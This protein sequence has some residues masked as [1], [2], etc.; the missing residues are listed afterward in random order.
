MRA[1][2]PKVQPDHLSEGDGN[3]ASKDSTQSLGD[4]FWNRP[5][6]PPSAASLLAHPDPL[7]DLTT[8][9]RN[10]PTSET[11][12]R[13]S[14]ARLVG[15]IVIIAALAIGTLAVI[16]APPFQP[17]SRHESSSSTVVG[18]RTDVMGTWSVIA[19]FG[20]SHYMETL[21]I[22]EENDARGT[23]SGTVSSPVG[24]ETIRGIVGLM[25]MSFTMSLGAD[26]D[27][28][29]ATV[30]THDGQLRIRGDFSNTGGGRGTIAA[31]RTSP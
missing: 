1:I 10:V 12:L 13:I 16:H 4:A 21:H 8:S 9:S 22:T 11:R 28:G 23:F 18:G 31:T 15:V 25:T 24:V 30:S 5:N 6:R 19:T 26:T 17:S 2:E 3:T 7:V 29:T 27:T 20:A 14:L